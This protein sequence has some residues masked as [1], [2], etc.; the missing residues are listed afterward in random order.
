VR[1]KG[2]GPAPNAPRIRK[3]NKTLAHILP[4]RKNPETVLSAVTKSTLLTK[5]HKHFNTKVD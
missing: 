3:K 2:L 4:I 1:T 5:P